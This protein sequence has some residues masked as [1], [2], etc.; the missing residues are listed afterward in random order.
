MGNRQGTI[1]YTADDMA[2]LMNLP[3]RGMDR[4]VLKYLAARQKTVSGTLHMQKGVWHSFDLFSTE[5]AVFSAPP[6]LHPFLFRLGVFLVKDGSIHLVTE[7]IKPL[8]FVLPKTFTING[9]DVQEAGTYTYHAF[10]YPDNHHPIL[11]LPF[12]VDLFLTHESVSAK[13]NRL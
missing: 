2:F 9:G 13:G 3:P 10:S 8:G 6:E 7:G 5:L 1:H 12:P 4:E 11:P